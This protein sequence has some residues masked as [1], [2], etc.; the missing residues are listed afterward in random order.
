MYEH[1]SL[2]RLTGTP[3]EMKRP[4]VSPHG[5]MRVAWWTIVAFA[6]AQDPF[7]VLGVPG[8]YKC[9]A[10]VRKC[11]KMSI[12]KFTFKDR[13]RFDR[14]GVFQRVVQRPHVFCFFEFTSPPLSMHYSSSPGPARGEPR[15][16]EAG[17]PRARPR[18]ARAG[19]GRALGGLVW[20]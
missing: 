17:L 7:T 2:L 9:G 15:G 18:G 12:Y 1:G 16:G 6:A 5:A 14:E 4:S 19:A 10:E 3:S 20:G 8:G 13:L 11:C